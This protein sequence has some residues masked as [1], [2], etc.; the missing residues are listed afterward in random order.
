M[1]MT[2][3]YW[4]VRLTLTERLRLTS[5]PGLR[6]ALVATLARSPNVLLS[7]NKGLLILRSAT[8]KK[9]LLIHALTHLQGSLDSAH[10]RSLVTNDKIATQPRDPLQRIGPLF[11]HLVD[12]LRQIET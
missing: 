8:V 4:P 11:M 9:S 1:E 7:L 12:D 2:S 10:G 6:I 3:S 5:I